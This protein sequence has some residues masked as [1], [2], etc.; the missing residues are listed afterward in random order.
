MKL[1][2]LYCRH[3]KKI[4]VT[5]KNDQNVPTICCGEPMTPIT[6]NTVDAAREK[7]V[8]DVKVSGNQIEVVVG[9]VE[10]PMLPEH[11]IEFIVLETRKGFQIKYLNAGNKPKAVFTVVDDEAVAVYEHCNLHGLW[12]TAL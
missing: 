7:H 3:C 1:E 6:A 12:K 10:H 11:W 4:I 5:L 2:F 9:S 8:P